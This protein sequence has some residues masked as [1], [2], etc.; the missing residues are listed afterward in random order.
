[1]GTIASKY[2]HTEANL[3]VEVECKLL[4]GRETSRFLSC[5][6]ESP[7]LSESHPPFWQTPLAN[8]YCGGTSR[9][10]KEGRV[11]LP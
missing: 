5:M 8:L 1:M 6:Q 2:S 10:P 3:Q 4:I 11:K 9:D 7:Q